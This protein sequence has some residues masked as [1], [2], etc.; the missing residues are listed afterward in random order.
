MQ[1]A[2]VAT[3][4]PNPHDPAPSFGAVPTEY[5]LAIDIHAKCH[6]AWVRGMLQSAKATAALA[7][8]H[9]RILKVVESDVD[10]ACSNGLNR[11]LLLGI[12]GLH[13][14]KLREHGISD[15]S[16]DLAMIGF[17]KY[18]LSRY[19]SISVPRFPSDPRS[20]LT[21][22]RIRCYDSIFDSRDLQFMSA[23][24]QAATRSS[25]GI[26]SVAGPTELSSCKATATAVLRAR[27]LLALL[28]E[29]YV[30]NSSSSIEDADCPL[31]HIHSTG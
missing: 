20:K 23:V 15:K 31:E 4:D 11:T 22:S 28:R 17:V 1:F 14:A 8:S 29:E 10:A 18:Y 25:A 16:Q 3:R 24:L 6:H 30:G 5:T 2:S 27:Q 13:K 26:R 21:L 19:T 7:L 9:S 12:L